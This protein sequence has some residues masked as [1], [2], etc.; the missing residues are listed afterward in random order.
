MTHRH[1]YHKTLKLL[2]NGKSPCVRE[3]KRTSLGTS[4]KL[5]PPLFRANALHNRLFSESPT[6]SKKH[7]VWRPFHRSCLKANKI[8]KSEGI[9]KVE[10][11]YHFCRG[12]LCITPAIAGMRCLSVR[13]SITFVSCTKTNKDIFEIFSPSGS[14]AILVSPYQTKWRYS[15]GNPHNGGVECKGV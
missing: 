15:D 3:S 13:L 8:S 12:M 2:I 4:A 10:Y 5:K 9:R 14:Q 7:I 6:A 11:A 1:A